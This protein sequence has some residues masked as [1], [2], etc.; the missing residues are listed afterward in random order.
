MDLSI[1]SYKTFDDLRQYC[2][3]VA[4]VVGAGAC[5]W[6]FGTTVSL[7]AMLWC[8]RPQYSLHATRYSP[9][10]NWVVN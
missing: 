4:S 9:A 6:S 7:D 8:P 3:R 2:Y 5:H 1:R 10:S